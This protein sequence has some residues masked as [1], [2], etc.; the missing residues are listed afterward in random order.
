M[1]P[2]RRLPSQQTL[3]VTYLLISGV[4]GPLANAVQADA[5][6]HPMRYAPVPEYAG[7][8]P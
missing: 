1:D 7:N 3:R 6:S 5:S 4:P 8:L 2:P